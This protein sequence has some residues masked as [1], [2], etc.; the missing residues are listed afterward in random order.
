V[1]GHDQKMFSG[2]SPTFAPDRCP[3]HTFKFVS[4]PLVATV[5]VAFEG[6]V[7]SRLEQRKSRPSSRSQRRRHELKYLQPSF[8]QV[9]GV[10]HRLR[11]CV[12]P[13][14][15]GRVAMTTEGSI[16]RPTTA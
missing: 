10:I 5:F 11:Y 12:L 7:D 13:T 15:L 8:R 1:K 9:K 2:A 14:Y 16:N 6:D 4:A 3:P